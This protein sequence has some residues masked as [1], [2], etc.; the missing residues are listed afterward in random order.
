[1]ELILIRHGETRWNR[2]RRTQGFSDIEL[3]EK[4][5]KQAQ[6]LAESLT[7]RKIDAIY[8]SPLKR[9]LKTAETIAEPQGLTVQLFPEL[10]ELNQG[11]IE[12]ITFQELRTKYKEL[13][14][15][16]LENPANLKM[17][18]GES[19]K[20]LQDRG[21]K[22][23]TRIF[24]AH[25]EGTVAAVSHNLCIITILCKVLNLELSNFR[26]IRQNNSA[27]NIIEK[28]EERGIVLTLMNDTCH[29]EGMNTI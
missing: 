9:A 13:L 19:M 28:T 25:K 7:T 14:K 16:W 5:L 24:E 29:M 6:K 8:S 23:I 11:D 22:A 12:G 3:T 15:E 1:M 17:P 2:E 10:M 20:E 18:N 21:W 27:I 4:G 26:H